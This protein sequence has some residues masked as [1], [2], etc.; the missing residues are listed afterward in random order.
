MFCD[1]QSAIRPKN[2][3]KQRYGCIAIKYIPTE[4]QLGDLYIKPVHATRFENYVR[5]SMSL[6]IEIH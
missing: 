4:D 3:E 2:R 5:C 1:N 6:N